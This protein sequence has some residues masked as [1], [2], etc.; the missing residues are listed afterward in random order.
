MNRDRYDGN[1]FSGAKEQTVQQANGNV[2]LIKMDILEDEPNIVTGDPTYCKGCYA[3][4]SS[5]SVL[6]KE[7]NGKQ[8]M[9]IW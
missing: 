8:S 2:L 4:L 6:E 3:I 5:T 7:E 9:W 1:V